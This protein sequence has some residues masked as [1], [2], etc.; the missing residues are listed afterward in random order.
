M[1]REVEL[2]REKNGPTES[3]KET[4]EQNSKTRGRRKADQNWGTIELGVFWD[5]YSSFLDLSRDPKTSNAGLSL[6][7]TR[8]YSQDVTAVLTKTRDMAGDRCSVW[9]L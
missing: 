5:R 3:W 8:T 6:R 1:S 4:E 2:G 9:K 7:Y